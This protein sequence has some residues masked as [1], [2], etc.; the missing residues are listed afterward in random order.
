MKTSYK[1]ISG[2]VIGLTLMMGMTSCDK[3]LD[4]LPDNRAEIKSASDIS[5]LLVSAYPREY[6]A[7]ILETESDNADE[8]VNNS[9]TEAGLLQREAYQWKDISETSTDS[10][11]VIW[12][13]CYTAVSTANEAIQQIDS[14]SESMSKQLGEALLCRAYSE[15]VLSNVFCKAYDPKTAGS[16]LG[17]PYPE[18]PE[19]RVGET[20]ERGTMADLYKKIDRDIQR[21]LPLVGDDYSTP[22]FHFTR[23]AAYAF[24]ARFYLYYQ[25]PEQTIKYATMALGSDP[26]TMLRDWASWDALS[27]N[28]NIRPDAYVNSGVNANIMLLMS[29]SQWCAIAGPYFYGDRYCINSLIAKKEVQEAEGPWGSADNLYYGCFSNTSLAKYV[30]RKLGY[31]FDEESSGSGLP[32]TEY[33]VFNGEETLLCRAEAYA[34]TQQYQKAV[35]D[36]NAILSKFTKNGVQLTIEGVKKYYDNIKYYTP[37]EPTPKKQLNPSFLIDKV[38]EEPLLQCILQLRRVLTVHEGLRWQDINRYGIVIYRRRVSSSGKVTA[39]T[40]TLTLNDPRRAIQLPADVISSGMTP[41]PRN[42]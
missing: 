19:K 16:D 17:L 24:A 12:S 40:D 32:Y 27:E 14:S 42:N 10:P 31:Y 4:E 23:A 28:K 9:W 21:A 8:N 22:K 13:S 1:Y 2:T 39:V 36:V 26:T 18:Q 34:L 3:F 5:N 33:A 6:P 7:Y 15:F 11:N 35:D 30:V 38:T 41:N 20:F 29:V 37:E 25:Q